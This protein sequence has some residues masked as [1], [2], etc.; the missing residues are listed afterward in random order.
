MVNHESAEVDEHCLDN[1]DWND[2][3][4]G[5]VPVV[6]HALEDRQQHLSQQGF[7]LLHSLEQSSGN[8]QTSWLCP[9]LATH[10]SRDDL[11][12]LVHIRHDG[13]LELANHGYDEH[14]LGWDHVLHLVRPVGRVRHH[15]LEQLLEDL[16]RLLLRSHE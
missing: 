7:A 14:P 8:Q 13:V 10:Q 5:V 4:L 3:F 12:D 16:V 1:G 2:S 6:V 9:H 11:T 15:V